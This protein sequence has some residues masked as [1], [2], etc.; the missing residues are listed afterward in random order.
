M[1][2]SVGPINIVFFLFFDQEIENFTGFKDFDCILRCNG[3]DVG[4]VSWWDGSS[5]RSGKMFTVSSTL[6]IDECRG[7]MVDL[8]EFDFFHCNSSAKIQ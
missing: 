5:C 1:F 7:L 4:T 2:N 3:H 8:N 6:I